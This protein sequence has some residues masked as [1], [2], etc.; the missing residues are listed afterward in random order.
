MS[1]NSNSGGEHGY[2]RRIDRLIA[3]HEHALDALRT[4]RAL[5]NGDVREKKQRRNDA[6]TEALAAEAVQKPKKVVRKMSGRFTD[7]VIMKRRQKSAKFLEQF[8]R[9]TPKLFTGPKPNPFVAKGYLRRTPEGYLRTAKEW[10]V[11]LR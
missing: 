2:L 7:S 9:E 4:T 3:Q 10:K 1:G 8:D 11:A 6:L 5:L